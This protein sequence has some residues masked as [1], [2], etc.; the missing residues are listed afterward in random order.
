MPE[1]AD[2]NEID[3]QTFDAA[4]V[5]LGDICGRHEVAAFL[6]GLAEFQQA[7][8]V[9]GVDIPFA[10]DGIDS[11]GG[12]R[13]DEVDFAVGFVAPETN[14]SAWKQILHLPRGM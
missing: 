13:D 11:A 3:F 4:G 9:E 8:S 1:L 14:A 5:G 12:L 10:F 7:V 6:V 2:G